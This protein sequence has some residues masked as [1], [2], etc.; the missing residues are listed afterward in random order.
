LGVVQTT[1]CGFSAFAK[2][3]NAQLPGAAAGK[4]SAFESAA[5]FLKLFAAMRE[6]P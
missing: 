4:G 1:W 6:T 3:C 2:A 5:C